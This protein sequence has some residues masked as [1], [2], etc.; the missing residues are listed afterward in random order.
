M[1]ADKKYIFFKCW[2]KGKEKE[3]LYKKQRNIL[4]EIN[5]HIKINL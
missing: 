1:W 3:S 4:E 5:K 2:I